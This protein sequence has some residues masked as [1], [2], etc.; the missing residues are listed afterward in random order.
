MPT[1]RLNPALVENRI[2]LI[3]GAG[4]SVPLGMPTTLTIRDRLWNDPVAG[5]D[6]AELWESAAY[7][8]HLSPED[9]NLEE[10]VEHTYELQLMLW[11]RRMSELPTIL[12]KE[13]DSID[14]ASTR[15]EGALTRTRYVLHQSCGD[16]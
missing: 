3:L 8:F 12:P 13:D 6:L 4:A 11:V 1:P 5:S 9:V 7:R 15:I 14:G 10:F 2:V 16:C